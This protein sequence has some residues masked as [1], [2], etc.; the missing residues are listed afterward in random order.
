MNNKEMAELS[1]K[2]GEI[3]THVPIEDTL[4]QIKVEEWDKAKVLEIF[5]ELRFNRYIERFN[6]KENETQK[7]TKIEKID[8]IE[9]EEIPELNGKLFY[10]SWFI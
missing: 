9:T 6:L 1:R 4:E 7:T 5:E 2:L 3:N 8:V 10:Y